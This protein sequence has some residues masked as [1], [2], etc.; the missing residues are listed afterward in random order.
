[1]FVI[2]FNHY[3]L[4]LLSLSFSLFLHRLL[5]EKVKKYIG[6]WYDCKFVE[7]CVKSQINQCFFGKRG[8]FHLRH[9]YLRLYAEH[10]IP[11]LGLTGLIRLSSDRPTAVCESLSDQA[12]TQ[13]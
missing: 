7:N 6:K 11:L 9:T 8:L 10:A 3:P 12:E 2:L 1:M 5:S 4:N 13:K